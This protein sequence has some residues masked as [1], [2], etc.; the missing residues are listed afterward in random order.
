MVTKN[1]QKVA[2]DSIYEAFKQM[3]RDDKVKRNMNIMFNRVKLKM[4]T[5]GFTYIK[6]GALNNA[7]ARDLIIQ[8]LTR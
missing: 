1:C 7:N 3:K 2:F 6:Y 4:Y 8:D 5:I